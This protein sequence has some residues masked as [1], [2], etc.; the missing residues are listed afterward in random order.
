VHSRGQS[1]ANGQGIHRPILRYADLI[2]CGSRVGV[3]A[4]EPARSSWPTPSRRWCVS[5]VVPVSPWDRNVTARGAS[6]PR[7]ARTPA[8]DALLIEAVERQP[9]RSLR[10]APSEDPPTTW[11]RRVASLPF[12][13]GSARLFPCRR[14]RQHTEHGLLTFFGQ[15]KSVERMGMRSTSTARDNSH[16]ISEHVCQVPE[17]SRTLSWAPAT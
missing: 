17:S 14:T 2:T 4:L 5:T 12:P 10:T 8:S 16:A 3:P 7:T 13:S 9:W 1:W 15:V 6:R 11:W